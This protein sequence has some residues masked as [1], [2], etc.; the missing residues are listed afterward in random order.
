MGKFFFGAF[1]SA[2]LI[3]GYQHFTAVIPEQTLSDTT[4]VQLADQVIEVN[5]TIKPDTLKK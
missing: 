5:D 1:L 2:A 4:K 3:L